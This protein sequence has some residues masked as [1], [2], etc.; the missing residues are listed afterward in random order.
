[1]PPSSF[2]ISVS[3]EGED[4]GCARALALR[5][6]GVGSGTSV[7]AEVGLRDGL[8][9]VGLLVGFD[10]EGLTV[11]LGVG[12]FVGLGAVGL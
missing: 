2:R 10:L 4:V 8:A 7:G 1:M 12:L 11:F 3:L 6:L 5:G 9:F